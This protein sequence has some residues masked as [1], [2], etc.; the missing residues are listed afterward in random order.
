VNLFDGSYPSFMSPGAATG[1]IKLTGTV[2][3]INGCLLGARTFVSRTFTITTQPQPAPV[4]T[5]GSLANGATYVSGGLVPGSWAQVKGT[6]LAN[7]NRIW[8]GY[9]FLG[10]NNSLPTS[11]RSD[12]EGVYID[13]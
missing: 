7:V 13:Q 12:P 10:L 9:D 4:L 5:S 6:G 8:T 1:H 2:F 11:L 3:L